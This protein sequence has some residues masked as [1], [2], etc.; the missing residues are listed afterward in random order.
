MFNFRDVVNDPKLLENENIF[1]ESLKQSI[2]GENNLLFALI[3]YDERNPYIRSVLRNNDYWDSLN[4]ISGKNMLVLAIRDDEEDVPAEEIYTERY[5][6]FISELGKDKVKFPSIIFFQYYDEDEIE[7]TC[8]PLYETNEEDTFSDLKQYIELVS[9]TVNCIH[10]RNHHNRKEIFYQVQDNI[11][12]HE[13][14]NF[15]FHKI[16]PLNIFTSFLYDSLRKKDI[17]L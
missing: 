15:I 7:I 5:R 12:N 14:N 17:F 16:I 4:R 6:N 8:V 13:I 11:N 9:Y 2:E 3:V 10:Q 1:S